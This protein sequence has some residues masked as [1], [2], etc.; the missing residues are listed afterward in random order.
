MKRILN[1]IL[2]LMLL[3][4]AVS[5]Q[6]VTKVGT[7]AAKFLSIPVG[8]RSVALAG[9][10]TSMA[11][12]ASA[13]YWN[14]GGIAQLESQELFF[15][16]SEWLA[17]INFDY[18]GAVYNAGNMGNF[19]VSVT[20]MTMGDIE[21]TTEDE[22]DGTGQFFTASSFSFNLSY[23]RRITEKFMIGGTAKYILETIWNSSASGIAFDIGTL[24]ETPFYGVRF[25][26]SI[27]NFGTKMQ[28]SGEDLLVRKD[29]DPTTS[30]NNEDVNA[31]LETD[32]FDLPLNLKFGLSRDFYLGESNRFTFA[33]DAYYPNDNERSL[34]IG[35]EYGFFN[36]QLFLRGGYRSVGLDDTEEEYVIGGGI[37]QK[38][39]NNL[40]LNLD[41][42]F[43]GMVNLQDVHLFSA[44]LRF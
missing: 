7:T 17:D 30:G 22:Q 3:G 12:D 13:L 37:K 1:I 28:I 40:K 4:T 31:I 42:A 43:Q 20:A 27:S 16:H 34:N 8:A 23:G 41:Y 36:E 2:V 10:F 33:V 6:E 11:D 38:L 29:I 32:R 14:P 9:A 5:A 19:G 44:S 35:A 24:F 18:L 15:M 26:T 39:V 21:I 25:G